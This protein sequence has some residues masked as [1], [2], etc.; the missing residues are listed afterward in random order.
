ME[1]AIISSK[2]LLFN[3]LDNR[4]QTRLFLV[5]SNYGH[6]IA[7]CFTAER[8]IFEVCN[9]LNLGGLMEEKAKSRWFGVTFTAVAYR[10]ALA[11]RCQPTGKSRVFCG[12][13]FQLDHLLGGLST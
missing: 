4:T 13:Q 1:Q 3:K 10:Y 5:L 12:F 2:V 11:S 8:H 9:K 7:A 6:L